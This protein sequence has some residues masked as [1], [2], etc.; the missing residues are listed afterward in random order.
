MSVARSH[1]GLPTSAFGA[2]GVGALHERIKAAGLDDGALGVVD[3]EP[4]GHAV[5]PLEGA[6]VAA[7]PRRRRLVPDEF[8]VLVAGMAQRHHEGPGAARLAVGAGEHRAGAE[9]HL[10]GLGGREGQAHRRL[11]RLR[12]AHALQYAPHCGVAAG[13]GVL[14]FERGVDRAALHA[15]VEPAL[16][17]F[18]QGLGAG[19]GGGRSFARRHRLGDGFVAGQLGGGVEPAVRLREPQQLA[20]LVPAQ[21]AAARDLARR[22]A[23]AQPHEH[24]SVLEHLDP[25]AT[26][27][28]P[29]SKSSDGSR[30]VVEDSRRPR[31]TGHWPLYADH[32]LAG[33]CR[34]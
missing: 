20:R 33:I 13:E 26:H 5:E 28:G 27:G 21:E 7:Q 32:G 3:D 16:H 8:D 23:R 17:D 14:A 1:S 29:P 18:A 4:L 24:L 25:S 9:V 6:A 10:R 22:V 11:W 31:G 30:G 2:L 12:S 19:D 34:S 15:G